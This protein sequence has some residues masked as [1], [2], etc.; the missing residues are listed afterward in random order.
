MKK[1]IK[2]EVYPHANTVVAMED[3]KLLKRFEYEILYNA[4]SLQRTLDKL[5]ETN[6]FKTYAEAG[7]ENYGDLLDGLMKRTF[8]LMQEIAPKP[9]VW[10]IFALYYDIH[11]IKLAAK[12]RAFNKRLD[13]FFLDY[14]SYTFPT[15]RSA[16]VREP[17]NILND[18]ILTKGLF[19]ALRSK[20]IRDIDFILDKTYLKT[21]K[22][23]GENLAVS[24]IKTF[25]GERIDL[26]NVSAYFQSYAAGH[27]DGYFEKTFSDDGSYPISEWNKYLSAGNREETMRFPLWQKYKPVWRNAESRQAL[28]SEMDVLIDNYLIEKTKACKLM[29]FGIEPI[30]AY[31]YNKLMEIKNI[32]IMLTGKENGYSTGEIVARMR[33]PYEL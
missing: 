18:V 10:K 31:F 2:T 33:I 8:A 7:E 13:E 15:I 32:R 26:Y 16:T 20:E 4:D 6:Y 12:E 27:P 29:P 11:N 24:H 3:G 17:D 5:N 28:L 30:C 14:G 25:I 22:K 23:Y 1:N 21:L 19:E 9:L